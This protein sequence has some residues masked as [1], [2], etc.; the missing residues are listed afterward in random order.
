M[1]RLGERIKL[2]RNE[3]HAFQRLTGRL[4]TPK[5]VKEYDAALETEA[6]ALQ[7]AD[8]SPESRLLQIIMLSERIQK[9]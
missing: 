5:T 8:S 4:I 2:T 6:L 3:L 9:E 1:I 7:E